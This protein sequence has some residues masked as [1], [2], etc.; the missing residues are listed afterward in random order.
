MLIPQLQSLE[1]V[2]NPVVNCTG[3]HWD[4]LL[5]CCVFFFFFIQHTT[6]QNIKKLLQITIC[7]NLKTENLDKLYFCFVRTKEFNPIAKQC[8]IAIAA[9]CFGLKFAWSDS[10]RSR[11]SCRRCWRVFFFPDITPPPPFFFYFFCN[12]PLEPTHLFRILHSRHVWTISRSPH[13]GSVGGNGKKE[14]VSLPF[15]ARSSVLGLVIPQSTP[16][17]SPFLT[18]TSRPAALKD[19]KE[20][21]KHAPATA[22]AAWPAGWCQPMAKDWWTV[23]QCLCCDGIWFWLY[24]ALS[25]C[26][27]SFDAKSHP[28][29]HKQRLYLPAV[30]P[31]PP[32]LLLW[33]AKPLTLD[34]I[35]QEF[36]ADISTEKHWLS[37]S[38][39]HGSRGG[40]TG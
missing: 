35:Y 31:T 26:W 23:C 30:C 6:R 9:S 2:S 28:S 10:S 4:T 34:K 17:S 19:E 3:T 25:F 36:H 39:G 18:P 22:Q 15:L 8:F 40:V 33:K 21:S 38:C 14:S 20:N 11:L 16:S 27:S 12:L 13:T 5:P 7:L 1:N 29:L 37:Q 24:K 32:L